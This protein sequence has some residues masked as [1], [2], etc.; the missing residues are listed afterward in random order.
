MN[1]MAGIFTLPELQLLA[2]VV[3]P[4]PEHMKDAP[5]IKDAIPQTEIPV[6]YFP[7]LGIA[8]TIIRGV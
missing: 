6:D 5:S 8:P 1:R 4:V 2:Q 7:G 3:D